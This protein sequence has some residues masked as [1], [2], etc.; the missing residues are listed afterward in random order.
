MIFCRFHRMLLLLKLNKLIRNSLAYGILID[1]KHIED[2]HRL[3]FM[4]FL[5]RIKLSQIKI[6]ELIMMNFYQNSIQTKMQTKHFNDFTNNMESRTKLRKNF[7]NTI[8]LSVK[9]IIMMCQKYRE[10]LPFNKLKR[11]TEDL[12]LNIIQRII[13][14]INKLTEDLS[15]FVKLLMHQKIK[16]KD[17]TIMI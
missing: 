5:K 2:Q 17:K 16:P 9:E 1:I 4:I 15:K 14:R 6:E 12:L 7:S 11:L 10:T 3:S 13:L 8:T